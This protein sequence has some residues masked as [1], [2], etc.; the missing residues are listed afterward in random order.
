MPGGFAPVRPQT[1]YNG[2]RV[3]ARRGLVFSMV[4]LHKGARLFAASEEGA[5][6]RELDWEALAELLALFD[7]SALVATL[8]Q[9]EKYFT[10]ALG[11][12][13]KERMMDTFRAPTMEVVDLP[14]VTPSPLL[15][16]VTRSIT[17][18]RA[19]TQTPDPGKWAA[20]EAAGFFF[21]FALYSMPS[22]S[23]DYRFIFFPSYSNEVTRNVADFTPVA[24]KARERATL[25]AER[26][27]CGNKTEE[28]TGSGVR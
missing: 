8:S 13:A 1:D 6:G 23:T 12:P 24:L 5:P 7:T 16:K 3:S 19:T 18:A 14:K 10:S 15:P 22:T 4:R 25:E 26:R 9:T 2:T 11:F 21:R 20:R 28:L 27:F 17:N